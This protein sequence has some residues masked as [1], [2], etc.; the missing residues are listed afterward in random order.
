M[1][2]TGQIIKMPNMK[3]LKKD[4]EHLKTIVKHLSEE[5][6]K[7]AKD[8]DVKVLEKYIK[9][10]SPLRFVTEKEVQQM[11]SEALKDHRERK[12]HAQRPASE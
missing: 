9:L 4:M 1:N 2:E 5:A 10:W 8:S 12:E 11:I 6:G 3:D 7:F